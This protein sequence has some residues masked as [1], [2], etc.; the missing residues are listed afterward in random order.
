VKCPT[1][2][3]SLHKGIV[4]ERGNPREVLVNPQSERLQ[5]FLSGSL[6]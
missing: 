4:E 2:W 3:Y 5:Q 1:N 6:K